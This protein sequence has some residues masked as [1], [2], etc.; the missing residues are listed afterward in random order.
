[1]SLNRDAGA[2]IVHLRTPGRLAPA[3]T[4]VGATGAPAEATDEQVRDEDQGNTSTDRVA[5][6]TVCYSPDILPTVPRDY[7]LEAERE[8][9]Q[10]RALIPA[11]YRLSG[12]RDKWLEHRQ[13]RE[14]RDHESRHADAPRWSPPPAGAAESTSASPAPVPALQITR[15]PLASDTPVPQ[16]PVRLGASNLTPAPAAAVASGSEPSETDDSLLGLLRRASIGERDAASR[17]RMQAA[18]AALAH[19]EAALGLARTELSGF[20]A[21]CM[22]LQ[23][24]AAQART[25]RRERE[26]PAGE[27]AARTH[28]RGSAVLGGGNVHARR[29]Q[30]AGAVLAVRVSL[31]ALRSDALALRDDALADVARLRVALAGTLSREDG[32]RVAAQ[33]LQA[34]MMQE[35]VERERVMRQAR[36]AV[37]DCVSLQAKLELCR[38]ELVEVQARAAHQQAA[39]EA[40]LQRQAAEHEAAIARLEST[41]AAKLR[42]II[43]STDALAA[44]RGRAV[45]PVSSSDE[46]AAARAVIFQQRQ[47][48]AQLAAYS[49]QLE[50]TAAAQASAAAGATGGEARLGAACVCCGHRAHEPVLRAMRM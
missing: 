48:L 18:A 23:D 17:E 39:Y 1:M 6:I 21:H 35:R 5:D 14:P 19:G 43:A 26:A 24:E 13:R 3:A 45:A 36:V 2:K 46:I 22:A 33:Q 4:G 8:R 41:F 12:A 32:G 37:A 28:D 29:Q 34:T 38:G 40:A 25:A 50:T 20:L 44:A 31:Q 49:A 47:Q 42:E 15:G 9:N 30:A 7:S 10:Q 11:H 27:A 16:S